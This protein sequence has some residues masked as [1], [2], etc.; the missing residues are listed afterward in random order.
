M[1]LPVMALAL[2]LTAPAAA[3]AQAPTQG[4]PNACGDLE[5]KEGVLA[6]TGRYFLDPERAGFLGGLGIEQPGPAA[7][8]SVVDDQRLCA[9]LMGSVRGELGR[10]GVMRNLR[11]NGFD[12]AVFRYGPLLAVLVLGRMTEADFPNA[13][14]GELLIFDG[15][16]QAY[17]GSIV[18]G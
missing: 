8:P 11:P 1:R 16:T 2:L 7:L 18:G 12:F 9:P 6:R 3:R 15:Q 17:L 10:S 14:Y 13:P 5:N 4:R